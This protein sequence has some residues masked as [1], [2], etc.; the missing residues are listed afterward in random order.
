MPLASL[1]PLMW[2]PNCCDGSSNCLAAQWA[3]FLLLFLEWKAIGPVCFH[4][5][6]PAACFLRSFM[7]FFLVRSILPVLHRVHN[8]DQCQKLSAGTSMVAQMHAI[9]VVP[10]VECLT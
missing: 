5:S 10:R 6:L 1:A 3:P 8:V 4:R 7:A 2:L 9:V